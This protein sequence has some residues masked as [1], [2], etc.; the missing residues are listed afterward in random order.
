MGYFVRKVMG[1]HERN[2]IIARLQDLR[3]QL[4][5]CI[6]FINTTLEQTFTLQELTTE[7]GITA[8]LRNIQ[9][10]V[11]LLHAELQAM[12]A[13][14]ALLS[15]LESAELEPAFSKIRH[16]LRNPVSPLQGYAEL[17]IEDLDP[18]KQPQLASQLE[19][20]VDKA[21]TILA[22]IEQFRPNPGVPVSKRFKISPVDDAPVFARQD[23]AFLDYKNKI[24]ILIVDDIEVNRI[25][26][27]RHLENLG[28]QDILHACNG[29]EAME[30]I[31]TRPVDIVLLDIDMPKM[32]GVAVLQEVN[33][34]IQT[35][36]IDV[37][38]ISASDTM[39]NILHCLRLGAVDF[40]SKPFERE[41]LDV[42]ISSCVQKRWYALQAEI[43]QRQVV[44]ERQ[45]FEQLLKAIF[46]PVIVN[47]LTC[48][49]QIESSY[50][51]NI[52]VI[53]TDIVG[54][55]SYCDAHPLPDVMRRIQFF[56]DAC[57][58]LSIKHNLQKIKTIGDCFLATAGMLTHSDNPVLDCVL[59]ARELM[60]ACKE[61]D[62]EWQLRSGVNFGSIIGGII[63]NR[64]YLYDIWGDTVNTASRVQS[65]TSAGTVAFTRE[66]WELIDTLAMGE[67]QGKIWLKGKGEIEII[68]FTGFKN[69]EEV[70]KLSAGRPLIS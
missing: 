9:T 37:L 45:R 8:D 10:S 4:F 49:G 56:S 12:M 17:I 52:A 30:I 54:F 18:K 40:L 31:R 60:A 6:D 33:G 24:T 27:G 39:Q 63:G 2:T 7:P 58:E 69:E 62:P 5:D 25:I 28:F 16:D 48:K 46:P 13:D 19:T 32:N 11:Q 67:S 70:A 44:N 43:Q 47:E 51:N 66:A 35:G 59:F 38:M 68:Q 42:R 57:E 21:K 64:Q 20:I 23:K 29:E 36:K 61:H 3:E 22:L 41:L 65:K 53:F 50:Y 15:L 1:D 55:T 26:L 34:L 14:E